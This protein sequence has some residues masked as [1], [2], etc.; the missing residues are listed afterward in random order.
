MNMIYYQRLQSATNMF[1][2]GTINLLNLHTGLQRFSNNIL[3]VF[4]AVFLLSIGLSFPMVALTW[5]A[6]C[7]LRALIRPLS[8][9]LAEKIGLKC[10]LIVGTIT[11]SGLFLVLSKVTGINEW[12]CFYIFYR[13]LN[14][15]FYW[16]PYHSYYAA[17][18]DEQDRGKQLSI[19]LGLVNI[20]KIVA[21][22]LGGL[23]VNQLGF[24]ALYVSATMVML[25]SAIPLFFA[26][27][28]SP[29]QTINWKE[30]L[31]LID[32]RGFVMKIG[33]GIVYM[34]S[35]VWTIVLFYLLDD[36]VA[37]GGLITLEL[38]ITTILFGILGSFV[39]KG[40]GRKIMLA[41]IIIVAAVIVM[42]SF[43]VTT[44]PQIIISNIL[45][46]LGVTFYSMSFEVGF[47]N[48]AKRAQNTLWFN[49]FGELGWDIGAML[50][51]SLSAGLY[52]TG[53]PLRFVMIF[54]LVGLFIIYKVLSR[55]Y[56][57]P[58][59]TI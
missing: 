14:D 1:R 36:Y 16:L 31:S 23:L 43:L 49:F 47:Y 27:D 53:V 37:F 5:A 56:V 39:D 58:N 55:F 30:A 48:L 13:A 44:V 45:V 33:E 41:G 2:N 6:S 29:G 35:F 51:L 19:R 59:L 24:W 46:A 25:I 42:R 57:Q 32:K 38:L 7:V 12:L 34:H 26:R 3:D 22:L 21:P 28:A 10:A 8:V 52:A 20:L 9:L 50:S 15:I 40:G 54:A 11:G 4:G 17:A 18:G